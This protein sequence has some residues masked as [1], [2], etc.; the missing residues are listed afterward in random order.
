MLGLQNMPFNLIHEICRYNYVETLRWYGN[1]SEYP[2]YKDLREKDNLY[3]TPLHWACAHGN[4]ECVEYLFK[5]GLS[6]LDALI[7]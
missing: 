4:V 2:I 1:V 5:Q 6:L 7:A 3:R